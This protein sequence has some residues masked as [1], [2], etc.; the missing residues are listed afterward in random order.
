MFSLLAGLIALALAGSPHPLAQNPVARQGDQQ[1]P[2][3]RIIANVKEVLVPV[4]VTD[5]KGHHIGN[6]KRSDF[7][8]SEDGVPQEVVSF[9]ATVDSSV[10]GTGPTADPAASAP[11]GNSPNPALRPGPVSRAVRRTY[12]IVIDTLHSSFASFGRV[13]DAFLSPHFSQ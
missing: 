7:K 8:V 4:V 10:L 12:L 11:A 5:P 3:P 9:R 2:V 13:R 6:L 1:Q